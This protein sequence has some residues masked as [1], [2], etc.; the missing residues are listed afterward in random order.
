MLLEIP[1]GREVESFRGL[2]EFA[3]YLPGG[4]PTPY[5]DYRIAARLFEKRVRMDVL[6]PQP[7][8][9]VIERCLDPVFFSKL[10]TPSNPHLQGLSRLREEMYGKLVAPLELLVQ[11]AYGT[12]DGLW[13]LHEL[14]STVAATAPSGVAEGARPPNPGRISSSGSQTTAAKLKGLDQAMYVSSGPAPPAGF[15]LPRSAQLL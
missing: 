12:T 7:L 4:E 5:T 1:L 3:A 2:P 13:P 10:L 14:S 6:I 9:K 15:R 11:C 8:L